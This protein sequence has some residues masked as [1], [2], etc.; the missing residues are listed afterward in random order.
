MLNILLKGYTTEAR[1]GAKW[2]TEYYYVST[3]KAINNTGTK[4]PDKVYL[5]S[6]ITFQG[7]EPRRLG[8]PYMLL[9]LRITYTEYWNRKPIQ[10]RLSCVY[11]DQEAA[12][13]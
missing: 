12:E 2:N 13:E 9:M 5:F 6:F 4:F 11:A 10:L 1:L 3:A 8:S 7:S